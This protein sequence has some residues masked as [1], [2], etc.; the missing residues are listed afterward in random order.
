MTSDN[1]STSRAPSTK[2]SL[3]TLPAGAA[4]L[5]GRP[6]SLTAS[7]PPS[8]LPTPDQGLRVAVDNPLFAEPNSME[9]LTLVDPD[10]IYETYHQAEKKRGESAEQ[11]KATD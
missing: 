4:P 2:T 11:R 5:I 9:G 8:A 7:S 10:A 3:D 6:P 1:A